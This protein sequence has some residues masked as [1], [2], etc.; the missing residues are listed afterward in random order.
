MSSFEGSLVEG[1]HC[2]ATR[3]PGSHTVHIATE[4]C[5]YVLPCVGLRSVTLADCARHIS[6]NI[7]DRTVYDLDS[8]AASSGGGAVEE[9]EEEE[10]GGVGMK[11]DG[12]QQLSG[13]SLSGCEDGSGGL[14]TEGCGLRG[15]AEG[16]GQ[17]DELEGCNCDC[18]CFESRFE[19]GNL[20]KAIQVRTYDAWQPSMHAAF[21]FLQVRTGEYDLILNSDI[22]SG[23]HH[24]WFYFKVSELTFW[25]STPH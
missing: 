21:H 6:T 10:E 15:V 9:E 24:Q 17:S 12:S 2:I 5:V 3:F 20:R 8:L 22:N 19:C 14:N 11:S 7:L 4:L 18:L 13:V 1:F 23:R 16:S 25:P